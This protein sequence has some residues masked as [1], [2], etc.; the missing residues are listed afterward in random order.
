MAF[1][2]KKSPPLQVFD[3][4]GRDSPWLRAERQHENTFLQLNAQAANWRLSSYFS[5]AVALIAVSGAIYIGAQPK[6]IPML[7]EVDKLGRTL[8]VRAV[9]GDDAITDSRRLVYREMFDLIENLRSVTTDRLANND[10]L[11]KGFTRLEGSARTYVRTE[12]S[13]APANEVGA[14]KTVQ[15]RVKT[16]L[17][18]E[19]KSWQVE[20]E[21]HSYS[22][23]GDALGVEQW[24]ATL[25]YELLPTGD[26]L[27][28]RRNP[29]GF[30]VT[31]FSWQK[32]I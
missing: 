2:N 32:V 17:K 24:K 9:T 10:R 21:E 28:I 3:G 27:S 14:T 30:T 22:L 26:E 20:W 16:A 7:V 29:I 19:G 13:K 23:A 6:F 1:F 31:E 4:E 5:A 25:Q 8:A 11:A 15:V 12:L 18:L